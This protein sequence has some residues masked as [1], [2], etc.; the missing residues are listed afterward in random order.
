MVLP[1]TLAAGG[2]AWMAWAVRGRSSASSEV[3]LARRSGAE[4]D[5]AHLRRRSEREHTA[6][7]RNS[8]ATSKSRPHSFRCGANVERL[9]AIAARGRGRP[10]TRS[11]TTATRHP[12]LCFRSPAFIERDFARAQEAIERHTGMRPRWFRAPF[13]VRWFGLGRGAAAPRADRRDVDRNR[14]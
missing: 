7:S 11:A 8:G 13:G 12:L 6:D 1:A 14:L 3:R 9:P 10:G 5:R 4:G 2:A